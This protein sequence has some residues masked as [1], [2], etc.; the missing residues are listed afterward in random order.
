TSLNPDD[1]ARVIMLVC[2]TMEDGKSPYWCYVSIKPSR[3]EEFREK[4]ASKSYNMQQFEGS[5]YGEIIVSGEGNLPPGDVTLQVAQ[6]FETS[7]RDLFTTT[8]PEKIIFD[9][10]QQVK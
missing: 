7:V 2:G 6:L 1:V 4:M 5:G 8:Y 3:M 10:L 9:K